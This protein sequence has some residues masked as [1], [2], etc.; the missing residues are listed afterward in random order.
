MPRTNSGGR[1]AAGTG[2]IRKKSVTRNGKTYIYWEARLTVGFDPGTGKQ[3]QKSFTGKTQKEVCQKMQAAA[4][5]VNAGTYREPSKLTVGEWLD[6]WQKEYLVNV[7]AS[8]AYLYRENIRLYLMPRLGTLR[9]ERLNG[10]E[11]QR[12]YNF[13]SK[14]KLDGGLG[15]SP[16]TVKNIHGVLHKALQQAVAVG[17]LRANPT[18]A[19]VL[20]RMVHKQIR[21]LEKEDVTR[22]LQAIQGHRYE[23]LYQVTLFTGLREGEV[24][25]LKWEC[26][27]FENGTILVDKQ[28]RKDQRKGGGYYFSEPKNNRARYITVA[29][30]V[31]ELL[32]RQQRKQQAQK[33]LLGEGWEESGLVFTNELGQ[34]LAYR[35]VYD[36]FKRI[37]RSIGCPDTRFHDLRHTYAVMALESGDDFKT[38]QENLG[39]HAASFTLDVYGHVTKGMRRQSAERMEQLIQE[40][41]EK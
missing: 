11:I 3:V 31:L 25:G 40:L 21:P 2:S 29:P 9:L 41:L 27:D 38:V 23:L 30:S 10:P 28:L 17:L 1:N 6:T 16:K 32:R 22:F 8:T 7:K 4:V 35:T 19:C 18:E 20:P 36:C 37:V 26:V 15:L 5:E 13:L 34:H 14:D 12:F 24:L 33:D 39:H